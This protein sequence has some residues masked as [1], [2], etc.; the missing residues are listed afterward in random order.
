[1]RNIFSYAAAG[2]LVIVGN[3]SAQNA[4]KLASRKCF[5]VAKTLGSITDASVLAYCEGYK[6]PYFLASHQKLL[7]LTL[8]GSNY[9]DKAS[10]NETYHLEKNLVKI[11]NPT[12]HLR[13]YAFLSYLGQLVRLG[14]NGKK[15]HENLPSVISEEAANLLSI[16]FK[17]RNEEL[18]K[19]GL[20]I[21]TVDLGE[22]EIPANAPLYT[23]CFIGSEIAKADDD[24]S[25][26][27]R[28]TANLDQLVKSTG[29]QR[30]E[31]VSNRARSV[32]AKY[33]IP[34]TSEI[35]PSTD[36]Y[37]DYL[38]SIYSGTAVLKM[39]ANVLTVYIE[40][41]DGP[42]YSE[43]TIGGYDLRNLPSL[44]YDDPEHI[45]VILDHWAVAPTDLD[46]GNKEVLMI[47]KGRRN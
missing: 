33:G 12:A 3:S 36:I 6:K 32:H 38:L 13:E 18:R 29:K 14:F 2:L 20:S 11:L 30:I 34:A 31:D 43:P 28:L 24:G 21:D 45:Q 22:F 17:K 9:G 5:P 26:Y 46:Q 41:Y 35:H 40:L 15:I 16:N 25:E 44:T 10:D 8:N 27:I 47:N 37:L 7:S 23:N 19:Q 1:M 39:D 42:K 4:E